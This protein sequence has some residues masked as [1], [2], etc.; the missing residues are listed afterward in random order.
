MRILKNKYLWLIIYAV[1]ITGV[2][3]YALFPSEL[4]R[5]QLEAATDSTGIVLATGVLHPALPL[6]IKLQD[7]TVRMVQKPAD[8]LFQGESLN[9]QLSPVSI[10]QKHKT[11]HFKGN[12]YNGSFDGRAGFLSLAK[13]NMPAEARI[14]F[15]NIDLARYSP[16]GFPFV[17]LFKGITGLARGSAFYIREDATSQNPIGKMSLYLSRGAYPLSEPFLGMNRIEFD[18]GEIQMQLK[19]D[20]VTLEKLEIYGAQM[21]CFLNGNISLADRLEE[22]RLNLKGVLEITGKSKTR[23]NITVDGTLARPT[24]RYI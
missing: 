5:R 18:R 17:P 23:M 13:T 6:G 22:S 2:F 21:N 19:N 1:G 14:N 8:I 10:F 24:F 11:I 4:V 12:A 15:H 3:L 9:L 20:G 7:I 16:T